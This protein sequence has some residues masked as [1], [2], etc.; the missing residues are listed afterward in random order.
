MTIS[1]IDW[2]L[3]QPGNRVRIGPVMAEL[4]AFATPCRNIAGAFREHDFTRVSE[5][6]H[7]GWS[8]VYA[9]VV[10]DGEIAVGD[11]VELELQLQP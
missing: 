4:T 8:R 11:V 7:P 10:R 2:R 6:L 1:G 3:M 9:R 5:R